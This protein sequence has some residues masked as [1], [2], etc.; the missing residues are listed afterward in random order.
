MK[1]SSST[2]KMEEYYQKIKQKRKVYYQEDNCHKGK[3]GQNC[4]KNLSVVEIILLKEK[5]KIREYIEH[6]YRDLPEA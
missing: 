5:E 3:Y 1:K 6:H 2:E 4:H